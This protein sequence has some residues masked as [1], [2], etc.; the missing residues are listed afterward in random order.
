METAHEARGLA[1]AK[2]RRLN[3]DYPLLGNC[4]KVV[5]L[6]VVDPDV[7]RT[8]DSIKAHES[9]TRADV[10]VQWDGKNLQ[11]HS[12]ITTKAIGH[13]KAHDEHIG[14]VLVLNG[15][16]REQIEWQCDVLF[17][18]TQIVEST[19]PEG[20]D[21]F[22][23]VPKDTPFERDPVGSNGD[24]ARP[25]RSGPTKIVKVNDKTVPW[26]QLYKAHFMLWFKNDWRPLDPDF[27]CDWR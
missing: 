7:G 12:L 22:G 9:P 15:N 25:I 2:A 8:V 26:G 1:M 5:R 14:T 10:F 6:F 20:F 27:Y 19:H 18:V 13:D 3:E 17:R 16:D 21:T 24:R 4:T 23:P 11:P